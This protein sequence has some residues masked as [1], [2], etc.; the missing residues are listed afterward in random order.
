MEH[1]HRIEHT[2]HLK[3]LGDPRR[4]LLLKK[5]M[6]GPQ[7]LSSLGKALGEHPARVRHHLKLL[8]NAGFIELVELRAVRGY[9]EKYYHARAQAWIYH[10]LILPEAIQAKEAASIGQI[11]ALGSHD[12]ALEMLAEQMKEDPTGPD[13]HV[14]PVGSLDGLISLRHGLGHLAGTHLWDAEDREYNLPFVKRIFPD[15][16]M[17]VIAFVER[18]QGLLLPPGNPLQVKGVEDLGK[19]GVRLV[20]RNLGSGTALWLDQ[21]LCNAGLEPKAVQG[22]DERVETHSELAK[23]IA[24]GRANAGVGLQVV[25]AP[26]GLD[27][28]PLF[29]ERYDLVMPLSLAESPMGRYLLDQLKRQEFR[30]EVRQLDGYF[31]ER[32]GEILL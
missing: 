23:T 7:T 14:L 4:L 18:S 21:A 25:A 8:E 1:I 30:R 9:V 16:A 2:E 17:R 13:L 24:Q 10:G 32:M 28:I 22:Y 31:P 6:S 29:R 20:N 11:V 26:F 3:L 12:L 27:F 15:R 19:P 5:L